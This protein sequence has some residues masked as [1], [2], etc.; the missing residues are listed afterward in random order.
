V[1]RFKVS[2][3]A[4]MNISKLFLVGAVALTAAVIAPSAQADDHHRDHHRG[5]RDRHEYR[6]HDRHHYSQSYY[7]EVRPSYYY[8]DNGPSYYRGGPSYYSG[9]DSSVTIAIGGHRHHRHHR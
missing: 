2:L 9:R 3:K 6:G 4:I 8:Y 7:R 1:A 5:D